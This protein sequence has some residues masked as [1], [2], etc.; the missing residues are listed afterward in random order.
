[1]TVKVS[2][3]LVFST[4]I[5]I[6]KGWSPSEEQFAL[7]HVILSSGG[8]SDSSAEQFAFNR[9]MSSSGDQFDKDEMVQRA[10]LAE[11]TERYNEMAANMKV[12]AERPP[13]DL[14]T[15]E[16]NLLSVAYKGPF[17]YDIRS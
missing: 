16:R 12:V 2:S 14:S 8:R 4:A 1:M 17:I 9:Q 7:N 10:K 13:R 15:E 3:L 6:V 11:Q 5:L